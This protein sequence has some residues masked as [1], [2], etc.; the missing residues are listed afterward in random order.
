MSKK[1]RR[2]R[3]TS[4]QKAS[5]LGEHLFDKKPVSDVCEAHQLQP[6]VLYDWQ[7]HAQANLSEA[8]QGPKKDVTGGRER[9][10]EAKLAE[11][12]ARLAK[13]DE[14]IAELAEEFVTLKKSAGEP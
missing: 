14:V 7:R 3:F 11:L 5:I 1:Q 12:T 10:L 2:R 4:E 13:K 8:L 6:S 9:V